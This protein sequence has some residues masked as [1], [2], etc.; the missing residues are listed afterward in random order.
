ME[1]APALAWL[2]FVP[3][4]ALSGLPPLS[5]F[6]AKMLL[7]KGAL[8]DGHTILAAAILLTGLLTL[9]AM[10]SVWHMAVWRK[11]GDAVVF[12]PIPDNDKKLMLGSTAALAA[13]SLWIGLFPETLA[14]LTHQIATMLTDPT[15]YVDTVTGGAI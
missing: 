13:L 1:H 8:E 11:A 5:G 2:W 7:V 10:L 12:Q 6:W 4:I 9:Y 15:I 14:V 3:I